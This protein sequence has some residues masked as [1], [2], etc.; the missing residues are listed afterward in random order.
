M[1]TLIPSAHFLLE[2]GPPAA[3]RPTGGSAGR[4][5]RRGSLL[6][7]DCSSHLNGNALPRSELSRSPAW[8][9]MEPATRSGRKLQKESGPR[10]PGGA[11]APRFHAHP[12]LRRSAGM[13]PRRPSGLGSEGKKGPG[14]GVS[15]P[16]LC[17]RVAKARSAQ[18]AAAGGPGARGRPRQPERS[19]RAAPGQ[20]RRRQPAAPQLC[21]PRSLAALCSA[22]PPLG[23]PRSPAPRP[24][25]RRHRRR[26][27]VTPPLKPEPF[28][29][30]RRPFCQS[31]PAGPPRAPRSSRRRGAAPRPRRGARGP[32]AV[33]AEGCQSV[34]P[35]RPGPRPTS[36]P[37]A[38]PGEGGGPRLALR[39]FMSS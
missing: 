27:R 2:H 11:R 35:I 25:R 32:A 31:A 34:L 24:R 9:G 19:R 12:R 18:G 20:L 4:A 23:S 6:C 30:R 1:W 7:C 39:C 14:L 3:P 33:A 22:P 8:V 29:G 38:F 26:P 10:V 36:P 17:S 37:P 13:T 16:K 28:P 15:S 21:A 5:L